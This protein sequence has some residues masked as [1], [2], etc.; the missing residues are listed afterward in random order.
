MLKKKLLTLACAAGVL[1]CGACFLPPAPYRPPPGLD[2]HGVQRIRVEAENVSESHH[3]GPSGV[4]S[5]VATSINWLAGETRVAASSQNEAGVAQSVLH[6]SVLSE[7]MLPYRS[8]E[9]RLSFQIKISA[10]LTK[11]N[12]TLAWR[13][14]GAVYST[15]YHGPSESTADAWEDPNVQRWVNAEVGSKLAN[16]IFYRHR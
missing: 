1:A 7:S 8:G 16:S 4:A 10:T 3:L 12:G 15:T 14:T 11:P 2:L 13:E 9:K 6:V 5:A